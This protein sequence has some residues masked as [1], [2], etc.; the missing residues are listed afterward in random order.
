MARDRIA[1]WVQEI[2]LR[3]IDAI[4]PSA[5]ARLA[6]LAPPRIAVVGRLLAEKLPADALAVFHECLRRGGA[7][8][9]VFVGDGPQRPELESLVA[10]YGLRDRVMFLGRRPLADVIG[11]MKSCH[12]ML[13]PMQGAALVEAMA[14]GLAIV[15]YD[16]ETHR[17]HI[18]DR[19]NGRLVPHR[20]IAAAAE[21]LA[22]L[23]ADPEERARLA[24]AAHGYAHERFAFEKMRAIMNDGFIKAMAVTK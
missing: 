23:T 24:R 7:G 17:A 6:A 5:E 15:A 10:R 13:A 14:C 1:A 2:D 18:R 21:A 12:L 22:E 9:L 16:H 19:V 3:I 11:V 20:D 4:P 8:S